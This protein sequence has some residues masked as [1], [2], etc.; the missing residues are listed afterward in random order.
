MIFLSSGNKC[1]WNLRIKKKIIKFDCFRIFTAKFSRWKKKSNSSS[2]GAIKRAK[3][4]KNS[5]NIIW[6]KNN[7][8]H[9]NIS[10]VGQ[11]FRYYWNV[12]KFF[13]S[14]FFTQNLL[15]RIF[16][17]FRPPYVHWHLRVVSNQ[18]NKAFHQ[19]DYNR[20]S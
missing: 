9:L 12:C 19:L 13:N 17:L 18:R 15:D 11:W 7:D 10:F 8:K 1:V 4:K 2:N 3:K 5:L 16:H 6:I 20:A 14:F